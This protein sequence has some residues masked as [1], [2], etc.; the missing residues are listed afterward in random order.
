VFQHGKALAGIKAGKLLQL[1]SLNNLI[2]EY[3]RQ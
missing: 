1:F 3:F 2:L